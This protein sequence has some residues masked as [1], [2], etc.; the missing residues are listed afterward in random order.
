MDGNGIILNG[1]DMQSILTAVMSQ[2]GTKE[3]GRLTPLRNPEV[4]PRGFVGF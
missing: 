2:F 1:A 3:P 4:M